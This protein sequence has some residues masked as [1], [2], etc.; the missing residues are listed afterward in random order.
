MRLGLGT[1][2][3]WLLAIPGLIVIGCFASVVPLSTWAGCIV[4]DT[5]VRCPATTSGQLAAAAGTVVALTLAQAS[6]G[7]GLLAPIYGAS[8]VTLRIARRLGWLWAGTI[9]V[10]AAMLLRVA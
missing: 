5:A 7:I 1:T 6:S 10:A 8:W 9:F 3:G 4:S 2:L